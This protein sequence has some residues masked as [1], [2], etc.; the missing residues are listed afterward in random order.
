MA[1]S[2][3]LKAFLT[4]SKVKYRHHKHPE[5]YT[6]QEIAAAQHVPGKQ[7]AKC[8]LINT[9]RG[10]YLAVLPAINLVNL[11]KLKKLLRAKKLSLAGES[12]IKGAFPDVEVGAMSPFGNLYD[13]RVIVEKSLATSPEIVCNAGTHTETIRLRYRDFEKLVKPRVG[14]FGIHVATTRKAKK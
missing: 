3:R 6:A 1:I 7:L 4:K 5:V 2:A 13:V 12:D 8:V 10:P 11:P 14:V 9:D